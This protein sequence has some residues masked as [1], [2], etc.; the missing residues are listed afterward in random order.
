MTHVEGRAK[1][2]QSQTLSQEFV[3][4]VL[5]GRQLTFKCSFQ[6][7]WFFP[8]CFCLFVCFLS[9]KILESFT[10][11]PGQQVAHPVPVQV[12]RPCQTTVS[13]KARAVA[14]CAVNL[15]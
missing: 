15:K 11:S 9:L 3:T 12:R 10:E 1:M 4:A 14:H 2:L 13:V 8:V 7:L 5:E 6:M